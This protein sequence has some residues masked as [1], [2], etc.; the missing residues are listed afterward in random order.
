MSHEQRRRPPEEK[1]T[2]DTN[3]VPDR[4]CHSQYLLLV[5]A[6]AEGDDAFLRKGRSYMDELDQTCAQAGE[7]EVLEGRGDLPTLPRVALFKYLRA[8]HR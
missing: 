2:V 1:P 8:M 4:G 7:A 3:S 6:S 5:R